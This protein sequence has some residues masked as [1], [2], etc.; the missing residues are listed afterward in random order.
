MA[1]L[2]WSPDAL[3]DLENLTEYISLDSEVYAEIVVRRIFAT[4]E[5]VSMFPFSGRIVPEFEKEK[6][7]EK[8]YKSYR[9]IYR[10]NDSGQIDIIRI[11]QQAQELNMDIN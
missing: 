2:I 11:F 4:V 6:V 1:K 9:I 10:T 5:T 8:L 7:R 3:K